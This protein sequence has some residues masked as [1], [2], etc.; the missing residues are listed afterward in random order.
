MSGGGGSSGGTTVQKYEPPAYLQPYLED[1]ANRAAEL[2]KTPLS[3]FSGQTYAGFSPETESA[4]GLQTSRAMA[5]SPVT[6]AMQDELTKTLGGY[7]LDPTSNPAFQHAAGNIGA[8]VGGM[9]SR[10]GRYG[11]GAMANQAREALTDLAAKTYGNERDAM[12]RAMQFAPQAANQ[13][14]Y[15]IAK[16]GEVG[17]I[18]EDLAQQAINE[19]M[20][21][22]NFA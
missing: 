3:Y 6:A 4:L 11:S 2:G 21:R 20:A 7:Y 16:L 12:S 17:G 13:D 15:D 18:R 9:F 1:E 5:G 22:Q 19:T 10:G 14:Y 8:E